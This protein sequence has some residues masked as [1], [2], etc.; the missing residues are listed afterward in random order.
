MVSDY[1]EIKVEIEEVVSNTNNTGDQDARNE[2]MQ[3]KCCYKKR[4]GARNSERTP[5]RNQ[6]EVH[7]AVMNFP[8]GA[9]K[10]VLS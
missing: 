4:D 10:Y 8:A 2:V 9:L 5:A 6:D 1:L 3:C 7:V